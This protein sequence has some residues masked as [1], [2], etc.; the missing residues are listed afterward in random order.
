VEA[1]A[2]SVVVVVLVAAAVV[3]SVAARTLA[4]VASAQLRI[5]EVASVGFTHRVRAELSELEPA[6]AELDLAPGGT[7]HI[8]QRPRRRF[9]PQRPGD[10]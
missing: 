6:E 5:L 7:H 2:V 3:V 4:A 9:A 1:V 8:C 10:R